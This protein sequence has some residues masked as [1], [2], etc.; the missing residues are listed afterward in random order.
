MEIQFAHDE[1]ETFIRTLEKT[2]I[3]KVLRT[4][5]LLETF[6]TKLD[7]PHSKAIGGKLFE[8]R[9]RGRQEVWLIYTFYRSSA[10]V[11]HGFLK[12][13]DKIPQ[14]E[15]RVAIARKDALD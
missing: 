1:I 13:T 15:L 6:G 7:M 14:R 9:I 2:T 12:K 5:D 11:L 4:I 10:V 8:L 3:A